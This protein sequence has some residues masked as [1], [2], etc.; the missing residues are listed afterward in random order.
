MEWRAVQA[1]VLIV[2][3]SPSIISLFNGE[4]NG[5]IDGR[6]PRRHRSRSSTGVAGAHGMSDISLALNLLAR[7]DIGCK[8]GSGE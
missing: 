4:Q 7:H 2:L 8:A 5:L 6:T 1:K 3:H